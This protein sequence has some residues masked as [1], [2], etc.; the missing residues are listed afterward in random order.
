MF[1]KYH[2]HTDLLGSYIG[3]KKY[4][5]NHHQSSAEPIDLLIRTHT[6]TH[7]TAVD[8][9]IL[10]PPDL[11]LQARFSQQ[12]RCWVAY[13]TDSNIVGNI[14]WRCVDRP[15]VSV[16]QLLLLDEVNRVYRCNQGLR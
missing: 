13:D 4:K 15:A 1:G 16:S 11:Y 5:K 8:G 12:G 14:S 6:N 10:A 9:V 3:H 7:G 2:I